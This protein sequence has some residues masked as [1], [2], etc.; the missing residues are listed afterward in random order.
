MWSFVSR[1]GRFSARVWRREDIQNSFKTRRA[2]IHLAQLPCTF[3]T[4]IS[5]RKEKNRRTPVS[6]REFYLDKVLQ[7]LT[8][9][10]LVITSGFVQAQMNMGSISGSVDSTGDLVS[11]A[12]VTITNQGTSVSTSLTTD[13]HGFY[14]ADGLPVGQYKIDVSKTGFQ[15]TLTQGAQIDPGQRRA[16]N[17]ILKIGSA[18]T[19][20]TVTANAEQVNTEASESG[21]TLDS[22]QIS[23]LC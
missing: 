15:E 1:G 17:V 6:V 20:L 14:S 23:I 5:T 4:L 22:K 3:H 8:V 9:A 2:S 12:T 10:L 18:T 7:L 11:G 21:G 16:N 19:N 13:T